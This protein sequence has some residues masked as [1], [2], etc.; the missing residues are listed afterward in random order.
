MTGV[1]VALLLVLASIPAAPQATAAQQKKRD[2]QKNASAPAAPED[3]A[4]LE[5]AIATDLGVIRFEF[6]ADKAPRHVEQFIKRARSGAYDGAAFSRISEQTVIQAGE[7]LDSPGA[8]DETNDLKHVRGSV[9]AQLFITTSPRPDMDG[10]HTVFGQVT[11]GMDVADKISLVPANEQGLALSPVKIRRVTIEPRR[12][13]PFKDASVVEMRKD[14]LLRTSLGEITLQME[15]ELAPE[16][17]RNFLKLVESGWY[18]RTAFHRIVPGFVVQGGA[19][20]TRAGGAGHWA[21]RYVR[22][23]KG[24]FTNTLHIRGVLS[25]ARTSDP[26]SATTSFFIVLGPAPHLDRKYSVFGKVIGGFDVLERMA[27][28]ARNGENPLERVELIEA[29]IKP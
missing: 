5:A 6:F 3:A 24:E 15:P 19:G 4:R 17:V 21:D 8:V 23:L 20:E 7:A 28:V 11:E 2:V 16:H 29:V 14:V 10:R 9:S 25:M 13:E 26:N 1:C 27:Q 22:P 12:V 18:D